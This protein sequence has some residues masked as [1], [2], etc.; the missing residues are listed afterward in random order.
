MLTTQYTY[1]MRPFHPDDLLLIPMREQERQ[2]WAGMDLHHLGQSKLLSPSKTL[3]ADGIPIV[4][5]GM[6]PIWQGLHYLWSFFAVHAYAHRWYIWRALQQEWTTWRT[7][8]PEMRRTEALTLADDPPA[9]RLMQHLDFQVQSCKVDY[10]PRGE[11]F[12]EWV[13]LRSNTP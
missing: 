5:Y 2:F 4:L 10:G 12:W 9:H 6:Q 3:L 8:H 1:E 11:P 13:W 7:E